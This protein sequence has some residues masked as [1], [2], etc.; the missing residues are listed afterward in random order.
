MSHKITYKSVTEILPAELNPKEHDIEAIMKS[1]ERFGFVAP[2]IVDD[3]TGRLV[4][5]HGRVEAV[6][7]LMEQGAQPPKGIK[8]S[9]AD[10]RIP[11]ITGVE[12]TE[13]EAK[14][15]ILA[16][17]RLS[18][19][20]GWD[21]AKLHQALTEIRDDLGV[22]A[23]NLAGYTE[24]DYR[25]IEV[26]KM[27]GDIPRYTDQDEPAPTP[28]QV[29]GLVDAGPATAEEAKAA[30]GPSSA[31]ASEINSQIRRV[32]LYVTT[33]QYNRIVDLMSKAMAATGAKNHSEVVLELLEEA[34]GSQA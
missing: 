14:A 18:E 26:E 31:M 6:R 21:S 27:V 15:Y 29:G 9:G 22:E 23:M 1:V 7:K 3:A 5:G 25:A 13:A 28:E 32:M 20:G 4:A 33:E 8:I 34:Y 19:L 16:D 12:F 30:K 11:V 10:W 17:N 2:A 24:A